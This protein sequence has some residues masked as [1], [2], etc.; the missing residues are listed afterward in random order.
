MK[1][2]R[3]MENDVIVGGMSGKRKARRT[4]NNIMA[5][6]VKKDYLLTSW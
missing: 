4:K 1:E 6:T 5:N 3:G 2:D